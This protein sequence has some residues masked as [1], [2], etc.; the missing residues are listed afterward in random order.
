VPSSGPVA[1]CTDL[2]F[3]L[4]MGGPGQSRDV[5][6]PCG[7]GSGHQLVQP[8]QLVAAGQVEP[9]YRGG[10][11]QPVP[12]RLNR[13]RKGAAVAATDVPTCDRVPPAGLAAPVPRVAPDSP[14]PPTD[15]V[16]PVAATITSHETRMMHPHGFATGRARRQRATTTR[17]PAP[18]ACREP[19]AAAGARLRPAV[20][21][22]PAGPGSAS[23]GR[24]CCH[25]TGRATANS[26][27]TCLGP[28]W[29]HATF[30]LGD[31]RKCNVCNVVALRAKT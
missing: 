16:P 25:C 14:A 6:P 17:R 26:A 21:Y 22:S 31:L 20:W 28:G 30:A 8:H 15:R 23:V 10:L 2:G 3:E 4:V 9:L 11:S 13:P 1:S 12:G 5:V 18:D 24:S 19:L 27:S 29:A 7:A